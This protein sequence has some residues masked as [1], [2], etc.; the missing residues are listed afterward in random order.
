MQANDHISAVKLY[1]D[2]KRTSG[3]LYCRVCISV[4]KWWCSQQAFPKSAILTF[5]F[6]VRPPPTVSKE[7]LCLKLTNNYLTEF[8][9]FLASD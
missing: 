7:I 8:L 3:P 4:A 2:P 9:I 6:Y 1:L 5:V